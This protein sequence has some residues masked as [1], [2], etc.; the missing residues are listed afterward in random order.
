MVENRMV[1]DS[2]WRWEEE[3]SV[4]ETLKEKPRK[5]ETPEEMEARIR[6]EILAEKDGKKRRG[7]KKKKFKYYNPC[8]RRCF[9]FCIT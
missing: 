2:E 1:V 3:H 5:P 7:G 8:R 4:E 6:A 9:K